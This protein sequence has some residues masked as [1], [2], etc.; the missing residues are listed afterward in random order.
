M[1]NGEQPGILERIEGVMKVVG[2]CCLMGMALLT[3]ADVLLRGTMNTPIFGA[4]EIVGILGVL[5]VG[6]ALPYAHTQKSHIG[7]EIFVRRLS[8]KARRIVGLITN[9]V[10]MGLVGVVSWRMLTYATTLHESGEVS[11]NLEL[12]EYMVVYALGA[13]FAVYTLFLLR[14]VVHYLTGKGE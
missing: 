13:G 4:E 2:A 6:L 14:D 5:V 12:P 3:G 9:T 7:V 10:T 1:E 8:R 11:M